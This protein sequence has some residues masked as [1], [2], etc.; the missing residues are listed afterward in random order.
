VIAEFR[1]RHGADFPQSVGGNWMVRFE[2]T[3]RILAML[4]ER[5]VHPPTPRNSVVYDSDRLR[6]LVPLHLGHTTAYEV[7]LER[8]DTRRARW[9]DVRH[10]RQEPIFF[11]G[12]IGPDMEFGV[13]P[14][15]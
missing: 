15:D 8:M 9:D 13:P 2:A 3:K 12:T 14:I 11:D 5:G 6:P 1:A 10:F 4:A 7:L